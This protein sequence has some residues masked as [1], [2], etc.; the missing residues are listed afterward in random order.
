MTDG[1]GGRTDPVSPRLRALWASG[2]LPRGLALL[3]CVLYSK[4]HSPYMHA[5]IKP[6]FER[7]TIA[8]RLP[9]RRQ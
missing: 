2:R 4:Q 6:S 7:Q 3:T 5:T 9:Y 1:S 8:R